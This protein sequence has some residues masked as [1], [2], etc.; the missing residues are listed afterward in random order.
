MMAEQ[1]IL[2]QQRSSPGKIKETQRQSI[3]VN[4][5]VN[6]KGSPTTKTSARF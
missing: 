1:C 4:A 2:P 3:A 6:A 5:R